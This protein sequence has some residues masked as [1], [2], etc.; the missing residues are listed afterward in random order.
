MHSWTQLLFPE[1]T[2]S[3]V[4]GELVHDPAIR[5][6]IIIT[7]AVLGAERSCW[8]IEHVSV[9][10]NQLLSQRLLYGNVQVRSGAL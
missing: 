10:S 6:L 7:V 2:F 1:A 5:W 4:S 3:E 8:N 9:V